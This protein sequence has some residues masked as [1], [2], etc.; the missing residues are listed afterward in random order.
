M[1]PSLAGIASLHGRSSVTWRL[2][3]GRA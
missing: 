3:P 1:S 2:M